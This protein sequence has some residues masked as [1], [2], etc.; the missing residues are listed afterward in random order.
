MSDSN[1]KTG[2]HVALPMSFE[3]YLLSH[4]AQE[5]CEV[6]IRCTKAQMFGLDEVQPEQLLTNR[7]RIAEEVQDVLAMIDELQESEILPKFSRRD[8][9]AR[10][11]AKLR[12]AGKFRNYSRSLGRLK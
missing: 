6:A 1:S 10:I 9:Q 12:K 7:Q 4:L 2:C 3:D 8:S 11:S 5:C